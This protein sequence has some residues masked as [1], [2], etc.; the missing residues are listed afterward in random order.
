MGDGLS[1]NLLVMEEMLCG[2]VVC[3]WSNT[4]EKYNQASGTAGIFIRVVGISY[5]NIARAS[6]VN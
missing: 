4:G 3:A 1:D 2:C 6:L 5:A